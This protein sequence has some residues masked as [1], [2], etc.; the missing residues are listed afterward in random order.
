MLYFWIGLVAAVLD[1]VFGDPKK[2]KHPVIYIGNFISLVERKLNRGTHRKVK[3]FIAMLL[4]VTL[5][6]GFV[7]AIVLL[8][9]QVHI[10]LWLAVEV[11]LISL[12]LAQKSLKEAALLVYDALEKEDLPEARRYLS[13]VVGRDTA[14]L[15]EPEIV[16]GVIETVSE[17]TSDGVTAPLFYALLFGATGA[18][19]YKAINTLDSMIGY[20][21]ERYADFGYYS[22][23]LDDIANFIPSRIS[24]FIIVLVSKNYS[25]KPFMERL[26]HWLC[27]AKKHP[28]PN[29]GYLEAATAY[30][31]GIRLGG[32]NR[33]GQKESFRAYMGE[34]L[35]EMGKQHIL[36]AIQQMQ[37]CTY[38]FLGLGGIIYAITCTWG[39]CAGFI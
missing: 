27:D 2:W 19:C 15:D 30:Q 8:A 24:G 17:N 39:K 11:L 23:K 32:F 12:A 37:R 29:S 4:T 16:R 36:Q 14:H 22:A 38:V 13:W 9:F 25:K 34:P 10:W 33:Y 6:T 7:L 35:Q 26:K 3:G 20:N 28:S 1:A 21:N 31:L 18:W 5:S